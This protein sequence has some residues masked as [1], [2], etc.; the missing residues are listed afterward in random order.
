MRRIFIMVLLALTLSG[1][2]ASADRYRD[3]RERDR[4]HYYDRGHH[5][6][7][8]EPRRAY[9]YDYRPYRPYRRNYGVYVSPGYYNSY[10]GYVWVSGQWWWN[11]WRY[12]WRPGHYERIPYTY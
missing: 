10:P 12:V 6:R 11:G 1:G 9:R 3:H 2:I 7:Y 8:V 4:R 5:R